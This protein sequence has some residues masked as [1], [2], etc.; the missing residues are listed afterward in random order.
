M[1][2][3]EVTRGGAEFHY[4]VSIPRFAVVLH[5]DAKRRIVV[6]TWRGRPLWR[7]RVGLA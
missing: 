6:V 7:Q 4:H 3:I 2:A 1:H 5:V